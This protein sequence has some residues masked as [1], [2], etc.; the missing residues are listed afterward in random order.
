MSYLKGL[1]LYF[2]VVLD[3]RFGHSNQSPSFSDL[4]VS[5][6]INQAAVLKTFNE[7]ATKVRAWA[8]PGS[9]KDAECAIKV[10]GKQNS[11]LIF[12]IQK[13]HCWSG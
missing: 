13:R 5:E 2:E 6:E 3:F 9:K 4:R 7:L 11:E 1:C 12:I 8:G 10:M